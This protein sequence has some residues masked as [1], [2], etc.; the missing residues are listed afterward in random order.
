MN[1]KA[2]AI[3]RSINDNLDELFKKTRIKS[4]SGEER[5]HLSYK[6]KI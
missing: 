3:R 1:S 4:L 5:G 6:G 2:I